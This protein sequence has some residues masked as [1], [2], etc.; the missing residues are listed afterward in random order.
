MDYRPPTPTL[1]RDEHGVRIGGHRPIDFDRARGLFSE[2]IRLSR[3]PVEGMVYTVPTG[4][5]PV[6]AALDLAERLAP[7][8]AAEVR[9]DLVERGLLP[10]PL[11]CCDT[12]GAQLH[13]HDLGGEG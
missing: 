3:H 10:A 7:L 12:E 11:T 8:L 5:L 6:A 9:E 2:L 13:G 1:T 4:L